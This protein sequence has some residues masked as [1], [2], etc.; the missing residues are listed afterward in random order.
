MLAGSKLPLT[1]DFHYA[2][3]GNERSLRALEVCFSSRYTHGKKL[4]FLKGSLV[5][6]VVICRT[7]GYLQLKTVLFPPLVVIHM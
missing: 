7:N 6:V 5:R 3:T 4:G 1:M 2:H